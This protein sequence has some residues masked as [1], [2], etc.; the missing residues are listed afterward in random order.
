[1]FATQATSCTCT[2]RPNLH[3]RPKKY[4][5]VSFQLSGFFLPFCLFLEIHN[6]ETFVVIGFANQGQS[7]KELHHTIRM[8]LNN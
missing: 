8:D 6:A 4:R 5:P 2:S 7:E 1:M 3:H